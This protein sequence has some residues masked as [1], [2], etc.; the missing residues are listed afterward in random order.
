MAL[1]LLQKKVKEIKKVVLLPLDEIRSNPNQPRKAFNEQEIAELAL[2]IRENG[3]LQPVTVRRLAQNSYELIAGERRRLAFKKIGEKNIPAIIE[4]IDEK[5]S[6][7]F[8]LIENLQR[9]DLNFFEEAAGIARLIC[10]LDMTQQ[11]I[12]ERLGKAQS[13]V[14]NKL[15][16]LKFGQ[17]M[18][19]K[20]LKKDLTERHARALLSL[21]GDERLPGV[22]EYI[23]TCRLN[24]EQTEQYVQSLLEGKEENPRPQRIF[25]IKD[26]RIFVNSINK[27]V[28]MLNSA[29]IDA[30][31]KKTENEDFIEFVINI[32]K[33]KK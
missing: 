8:A 2:S 4:E 17:E 11:Q 20:M 23:H 15:R 9:R 1:G 33:S 7:V 27:A 3:L 14:A 24:V 13:T 29:G 10:E 21:A 16:L 18:Q 12:S 32:P 22:I 30:V 5:Q 28:T 19:T 25:V 26:M 31:S 6:A